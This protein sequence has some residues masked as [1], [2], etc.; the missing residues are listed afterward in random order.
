MPSNTQKTFSGTCPKCGQPYQYA[1]MPPVF[2]KESNMMYRVVYCN[3]CAWTGREWHRTSFMNVI[4]V[5][6][7]SLPK[8]EAHSS[9]ILEI[10]TQE[11]GYEQGSPRRYLQAV[12]PSE[13]G[14]P[15][16]EELFAV[17][18][19]RGSAGSEEEV[20]ANAERLKELWNKCTRLSTKALR[21]GIVEDLLDAVDASDTAF[22]VIGINSEDL[23]PQAL[24]SLKEAWAAVQEVMVKLRPE[25]ALA[26]AIKDSPRSPYN[27]VRQERKELYEALKSLLARYRISARPVAG[28]CAEE[29]SRVMEIVGRVEERDMLREDPKPHPRGHSVSEEKNSPGDE[30]VLPMDRGRIAELLMTAADLAEGSD[31]MIV[32]DDREITG[33]DLAQLLAQYARRV[34]GILSY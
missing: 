33:D 31:E 21:E 27:V 1:K 26:S 17:L 28:L 2:R 15:G 34:R 32:L 29:W 22:A 16:S 3:P 8:T 24:Q 14:A 25:G 9:S 4:S 12:S 20:D 23:T 30:G 13:K 7:G 6:T 11:D 18:P 5:A 10:R 19:G